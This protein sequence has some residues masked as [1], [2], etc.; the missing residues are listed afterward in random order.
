MTILISAMAAGIHNDDD[1][2]SLNLETQLMPDSFEESQ[3]SQ[4]QPVQGWWSLVYT[5][6]RHFAGNS[7]FPDAFDESW[8]VVDSD[9]PS[10]KASPWNG[11]C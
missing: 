6:G 4:Y 2:D 7:G 5:R 3:E 1:A 11:M 8:E 9:S 10:D